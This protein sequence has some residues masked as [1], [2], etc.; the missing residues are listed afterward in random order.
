MHIEDHAIA[1]HKS[2]DLEGT[3]EGISSRWGAMKRT[4]CWDSH[5]GK[6]LRLLFFISCLWDIFQI[7]GLV[8][9][10]SEI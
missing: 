8:S 10:T 7:V 1:N 4:A 5:M 2:K 6:N 9:L 3:W